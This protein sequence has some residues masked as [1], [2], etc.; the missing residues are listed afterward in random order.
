MEPLQRI[1]PSAEQ[2]DSFVRQHSRAHLLQLS[3]WGALKAD[4]GWE[5]RTVALAR[6]GEIVAGAQVLQ[7]ALPLRL[8]KLAY[9]PMGP[10][11]KAESLY[12]PLLDA[13][14]RETGAAF[15]KLEPGHF[16]DGATP[17]FAGMG[18]VESPQTVQP[19]RTIRLDIRGADDAILRR[20]NQGTRRKIRKSLK[21][22]TDLVEG[23]SG[24]LSD[25]MRLTLLTGERNDFGVHSEAYFE[26]VCDLFLPRD[27]A[28]LLAIH[29]GAALAAI[30]VFAVG[31]C[32]WY[33]YG[34]SSR[35]K[36]NLYASYGLQWRAIQWA[37][38]RGCEIYD[39][40]GVPD[41]DEATLEAQFR[42]RKD[43]LW[44]VY[45]FKRGFGGRVSRTAG[46]WDLVWNPMVYRA[47]RGALKWR[48]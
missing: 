41:L 29:D 8:G 44:G 2:W 23:G 34:A 4:F 39:M 21:A 10:L 18:F 45:G 17:D 14:K 48:G 13:I 26:R 9:A 5:T 7:K 24:A 28:L 27:G 46:S 25:F 40:W 12:P 16:A 32:A 30:M 33:F 47:Y 31:K 37:K 38:A 43:G 20:M 15:L 22:G 11:A 42:E 1:Q 6:H 35:E 3:G 19:A 36:T